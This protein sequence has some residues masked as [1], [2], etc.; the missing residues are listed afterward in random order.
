MNFT[1]IYMIKSALFMA[2]FYLVY[3]LLLSRDTSYRRNRLFILI[4]LLMSMSLPLITLHTHRP[5]GIQN[6]GKVLDEV[7]ITASSEGISSSIYWLNGVNIVKIII[8]IYLTGAVLLLVKL[9]ADLLNLFILITRQRETGSRII[10]FHSFN[11]AGFSAMGYIFL[12]SKLSDEESEEIVRH[13]ENHLRRN[14]FID[15]IMIEVIRAFQWF[16]PVIYLFERS[17]RA[18]HEFQA[19]QECLNAG[20][21]VVSY[22]SLILNQV[23][24]SKIFNLTNSFS[25]PS[26]IKKRMLMMTKKRTPSLAN[27]KI[28]M[29]IPVSGIIFLAISAYSEIPDSS[30]NNISVAQ[31]PANQTDNRLIPNDTRSS[32]EPFVQV[33]EM[34][35]FPGGDAGLITFI[36]NNTIYPEAAKKNGIQGRVIVRFCITENGTLD[37]L[38][39][40]KGV[41]P[42]LDQEALR[43]IETLPVFTP[44]RN[45]GKPVPV[46][47]MLPITF[48]LK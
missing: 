36:A 35:V 2:A 48:A 11:T 4:S 39:I 1:V 41:S 13:E 33:E 23:F 5:I 47:Y 24:R 31:T 27:L 44:G 7:I 22:Q 3:A 37:R 43:V 26:M 21:T 8:F 29:A 6:F 46:W 45:G 42:E 9:L 19:D 38:S 20:V 15:I 10:K 18:I 12:N 34:P 28:L 25:N 17:L 30:Q 16:N 40:L 32:T 14:H